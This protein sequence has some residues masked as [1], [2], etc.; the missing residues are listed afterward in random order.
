MK[1]YW[2]DKLK[3]FHARAHLTKILKTKDKENFKAPREKEHL[4]YKEKLSMT[5]DF[6][7]ETTEAYRNWYIFQ[8][9]KN[10]PCELI[11][12]YPAKYPFRLGNQEF[13]NE[14]KLKEF[15]A[16]RPTLIEWLNEILRK[17]AKKGG[18][19]YQ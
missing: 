1:K 2:Q 15:I 17:K 9:L 13:S 5:E 8:V 19:L 3:K 7:S 12:L 16:S 11:T 10:E 14:G 4:T 6:S 18:T